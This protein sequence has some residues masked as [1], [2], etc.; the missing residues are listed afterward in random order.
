MACDEGMHVY[1]YGAMAALPS[2]ST[3]FNYCHV[4][5]C[6]CPAQGGNSADGMADAC[7]AANT[8]D[9]GEDDIE[10]GGDDGAAVQVG[11]HP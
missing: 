8:E 11:C 9:A 6:M 10:E 4:T 1:V 3:P 7:V 2:C 5:T